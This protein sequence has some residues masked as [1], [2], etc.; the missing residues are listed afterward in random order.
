MRRRQKSFGSMLEAT[1]PPLPR[2][3]SMGK[4]SLLR[5]A[6]KKR[7]ALFLPLLRSTPHQPCPLMTWQASMS[8]IRG[9]LMQPQQRTRIIDVFHSAHRPPRSDLWPLLLG[10]AAIMGC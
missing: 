6:S 8:S 9:A 3:R 10:W 7:S 2:G 1:L 5:Q 4:G